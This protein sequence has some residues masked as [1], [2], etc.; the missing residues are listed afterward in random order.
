MLGDV[1]IKATALFLSCLSVCGFCKSL[2]L[3]GG[4]WLG[5]SER[6]GRESSGSG[7]EWCVMGPGAEAVRGAGLGLR[8]E[9]RADKTCLGW[10]CGLR[11]CAESG[12]ASSRGHS[13]AASLEGRVAGA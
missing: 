10:M 4:D 3:L 13:A 11:Q 7:G 6:R 12:R 5:G 2:C 8:V 9:G 1:W